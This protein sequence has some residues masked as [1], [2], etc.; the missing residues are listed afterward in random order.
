MTVT[1]VLI[2][3]LAV[4][5]VWII[6]GSAYRTELIRNLFITSGIAVAA[7]IVVII[8]SLIVSIRRKNLERSIAYVEQ[9]INSRVLVLFVATLLFT[10]TVPGFFANPVLTELVY[11]IVLLSCGLFLAFWCRAAPYVPVLVATLTLIIG[12]AVQ[13]VLF[14]INQDVLFQFGPERYL[15]A[16][17]NHASRVNMLPLDIVITW[18]AWKVTTKAIAPIRKMV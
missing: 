17:W 3:F 12:S 1:C 9:F 14:L 13:T 8:L 15:F 7:L 4:T 11:Y 6:W 5:N 2:G 16:M 18:G 10:C